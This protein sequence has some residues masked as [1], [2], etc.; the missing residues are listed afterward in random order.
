LL[1]RF[2]YEEGK[3]FEVDVVVVFGSRSEKKTRIKSL[4]FEG[5]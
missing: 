5:G 1:S 4:Q 2:A 3:C